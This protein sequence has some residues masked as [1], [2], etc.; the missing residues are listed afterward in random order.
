MIGGQKMWKTTAD[1]VEG[2]LDLRNGNK[3]GAG[4]VVPAEGGSPLP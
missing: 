2:D 4:L 3:G 1:E